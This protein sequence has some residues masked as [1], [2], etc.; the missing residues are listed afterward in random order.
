VPGIRSIL[1][2]GKEEHGFGRCLARG[3]N[4]GNVGEKNDV[5][6]SQAVPVSEDDMKTV[7]AAGGTEVWRCTVCL[8]Q[9]T[10]QSAADNHQKQNPSHLVYKVP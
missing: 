6:G 2:S 8:F 3:E 4:G 7:S 9:G 10:T 5:N 1:W